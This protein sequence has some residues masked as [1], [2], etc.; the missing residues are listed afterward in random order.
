MVPISTAFRTENADFNKSRQHYKTLTSDLE[1]MRAVYKRLSLR[2]VH[3]IRVLR[4]QAGS[5]NDPLQCTLECTSLDD[6]PRYEALS[7]EWNALAGTGTIICCGSMLEV[8]GNLHGALSSLRN[9]DKPRLL[10]VDAICINQ[11]DR[12][13]KN[14]QV[15]L[16]TKIYE[17]ALRVLVW[18]G[19]SGHR[20]GAAFKKME[21]L[22][23]LWAQRA[24]QGMEEDNY[25]EY[26][27]TKKSD[28]DRPTIFDSSKGLLWCSPRS[29]MLGGPVKE[30]SLLPDQRL[31]GSEVFEFDDLELWRAIDD[32]FSNSYHRR[33]WVVQEVSVAQFALVHCGRF[34]LPWDLFRH[35]YGARELLRFQERQFSQ[36]DASF[37]PLSTLRDARKRYL[38]DE[39]STDLAGALA[40]FTFSKA[41]NPR[42]Y[43]Y[44]ALGLVKCGLVKDHIKPDY[45]K[46]VEQIYRE[47][48][49]YI[50]RERQDLYLWGRNTI[51]SSKR[52]REMPS[53]VPDWS[54]ESD[55]GAASHFSSKFQTCV[56][57]PIMVDDGRLRLDGHVLDSIDL[58]IHMEH[59][60]AML[61]LVPG[62]VHTLE[63]MGSGLFGAYRYKLDNVTTQDLASSQGVEG[64]LESKI[65]AETSAVLAELTDVPKGVLEIVS[66]LRHI[67][68][69]PL[70][71]T[72]LNIEALWGALTP[73]TIV[74][75]KTP[76]LPATQMLLAGWYWESV[77]ARSKNGKMNLAGLPRAYGELIMAAAILSGTHNI[78]WA[79]YM[80]K[81][82][83]R[84]HFED[85]LF[86]TKLGYFGR[87][88]RGQA[89]RDHKVA[90]L[91]GAWR[92]YVLEEQQGHYQFVCHAY[93]Q[94]IMS[95][96][97]LP[98]HA[99]VSRMEIR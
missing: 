86:V 85:D 14:Q 42:D 33:A 59:E 87:S 36:P 9:R 29:W 46:P 96:S 48:A 39:F 51:G 16:M 41:T 50:I 99:T 84:I 89:K 3:D 54:M 19:P 94:D 75:Q 38:N 88:P 77:S 8:T 55:A 15:A 31:C 62:V 49:T 72:R 53:W 32:L 5:E 10:W 74:R 22:A 66:Q 30:Y 60:A 81:H 67:D 68:R 78:S 92:P 90:I 65:F 83:S 4:L 13:E 17:D 95:M 93:V 37:A 2:Q 63:G 24:E 76:P 61:D 45:G 47:V 44:A 6:K 71:R 57:G 25:L 27:L 43:V 21:T 20:T 58:V 98:L 69:H 18:L 56:R 97:K 23:N 70:D 1:I 80:L 79:E 35:A 26:T 52:F 82:I 64:E 91:A 73:Q 28:L 40:L 34:T 7:Y 11:E 12:K